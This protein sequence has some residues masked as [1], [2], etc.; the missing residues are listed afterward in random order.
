MRMRPPCLSSRIGL[1]DRGVADISRFGLH[2]VGQDHVAK[3][4]LL[5]AGQQTGEDRIGIETREAPPDDPPGRVDQRR[6]TAIADQRQIE[7]LLLERAGAPCRADGIFARASA[8]VR[9]PLRDRRGRRRTGQPCLARRADRRR[10]GAF[11]GRDRAARHAR[12]RARQTCRSTAAAPPRPKRRDRP[13]PRPRRTR[14]DRSRRR[15]QRPVCGRE[16][17]LPP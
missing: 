17:V 14:R 15:R 9:T 16:T 12:R 5:V 2:H 4:L 6:D 1:D 13:A 10:F 3:P 7:R 11:I 8:A